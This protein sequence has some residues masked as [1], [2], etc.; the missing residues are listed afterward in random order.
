MSRVCDEPRG[1]LRLK[2]GARWVGVLMVVALAAGPGF[3][4]VALINALYRDVPS[5]AAA[6]SAG[7]NVSSQSTAVGTSVSRLSPVAERVA[8]SIQASVGADQPTAHSNNPL[9][10]YLRLTGTSEF[11][12]LPAQ[13]SDAP[14]QTA[15][16]VYRTV[17]VRLCDGAYFPIS[18]RAS[19]DQFSANEA[20]CQSSC[21]SPARLYVHAKDRETPLQMRDLSGNSYL[22]LETAFRFH[23]TYDAQC[24][25]RAQPWTLASR[26]LHRHYAEAT[27]TNKNAH[28]VLPAAAN[29]KPATATELATVSAAVNLTAATDDRSVLVSKSA[30]DRANFG[31]P[32]TLQARSATLA[33]VALL[34]SERNRSVRIDA[35]A[36]RAALIAS[37]K[38]PKLHSPRATIKVAAVPKPNLPGTPSFLTLNPASYG[39]TEASPAVALAELSASSGDTAPRTA[40]DILMRNINPQF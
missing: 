4:S 16:A 12:A 18:E 19:S 38:I 8:P 1:P 39:G 6:Q 21:G 17:C 33:E 2:I 7:K 35:V 37:L 40:T 5:T 23:T 29:A 32:K 34:E 30:V 3:F 27:S 20:Q 13:T 10:A 31:A 28:P 22:E 26:Q 9:K 11:S 14:S 36:K 15:K 25:C 24:T